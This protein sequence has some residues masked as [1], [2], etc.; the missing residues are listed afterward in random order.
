MNSGRGLRIRVHRVRMATRHPRHDRTRRMRSRRNTLRNRAME[1]DG[2][3]A[4][5]DA[6]AVRIVIHTPA[7]KLRI[8]KCQSAARPD[9][10]ASICPRRTTWYNGRART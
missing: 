4:V 5:E 6:D 1:Q 2:G 3:G 10:S 9:R 8:R 7:K